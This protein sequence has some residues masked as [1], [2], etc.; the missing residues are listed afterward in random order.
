MSSDQSELSAADEME[1]E[2][3]EN[4]SNTANSSQSFCRKAR[5]P[6]IEECIICAKKVKKMRDHL[7]NA[8]QLNEQKRIKQFFFQLLFNST[9]KALFLMLD[10]PQEDELQAHPSQTS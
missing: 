5:R 4:E 2:H 8:H 10:L 1:S 9:D 3:C 7:S 6:E